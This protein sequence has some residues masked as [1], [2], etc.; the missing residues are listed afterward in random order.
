MCIVI[1]CWMTTEQHIISKK[2]FRAV[3]GVQLAAWRSRDR[4]TSHGSQYT[5]EE[6]IRIPAALQPYFGA[7][8]IR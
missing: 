1:M 5:T 6:G 3:V 2:R 8:M 4:G 7:D